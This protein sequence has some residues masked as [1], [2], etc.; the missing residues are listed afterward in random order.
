MARYRKTWAAF[1]AAVLLSISL[2]WDGVN[3]VNEAVALASAW[4]GVFGVWLFPNDAP[5][6]EL[7]DPRVSERG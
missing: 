5:A 3:D 6:G 7:P 4:L 2:G 1:T